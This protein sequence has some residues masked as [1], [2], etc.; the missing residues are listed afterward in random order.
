MQSTFFFKVHNRALENGDLEAAAR[1]KE[2]LEN[3]QREFRKQFKSKKESEWW[4]PKW[5]QPCKNRATGEDDWQFTGGFWD[6]DFTKSPNI[7]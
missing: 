2:T 6:G 5:F 7:F 1:E 3:K 4:T